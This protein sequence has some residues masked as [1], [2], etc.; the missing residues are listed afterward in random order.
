M[1]AVLVAYLLQ[2]AFSDVAVPSGILSTRDR[3]PPPCPPADFWQ[4]SSLKGGKGIN[5][6][7]FSPPV[8]PCY[9]IHLDSKDHLQFPWHTEWL[10]ICGC[11]TFLQSPLLLLTASCFLAAPR[12]TKCCFVSHFLAFFIR[13]LSG[14]FLPWIVVFPESF[15]A[16]TLYS[17]QCFVEC[18]LIPSCIKYLFL[19]KPLCLPSKTKTCEALALNTVHR[20]FPPLCYSY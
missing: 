17:P 14:Q 9:N 12:Y 8:S 5:P 16:T 1:V 6:K 3:M 18:I 19:I 7:R 13:S 11:T 20:G 2:R 4:E 15:C 10:D